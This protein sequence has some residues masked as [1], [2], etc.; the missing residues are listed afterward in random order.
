[1]GSWQQ[2]QSA[3]GPVEEFSCSHGHGTLRRRIHVSLNKMVVRA[4][5]KDASAA[6]A[7]ARP[8]VGPVIVESHLL[9]G[10]RALPVGVL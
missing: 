10:R 3:K 8:L 5:Y 1:M 7:S 2:L 9:A 6:Q 4:V